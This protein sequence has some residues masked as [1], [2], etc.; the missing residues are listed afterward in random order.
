MSYC[1]SPVRS[2]GA[3]TQ[4]CPE[5]KLV[6]ENKNWHKGLLKVQIITQCMYVAKGNDAQKGHLHC[7]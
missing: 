3:L 2:K 7:L 5:P 6:Q 1:L 4:Y